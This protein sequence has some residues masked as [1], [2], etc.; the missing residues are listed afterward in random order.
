[1]PSN[2]T[3]YLMAANT[4]NEPIYDLGKEETVNF[5][6]G[7]L[8]Q[9]AAPAT[10]FGLGHL[11]SNTHS[12]LT[13]DPLPHIPFPPAVMVAELLGD[14]GQGSPRE[15]SKRQNRGVRDGCGRKGRI[16]IMDDEELIRNVAAEMIS[17]LGHEVESVA[18]GSAA[19]DAFARARKEG[20]PFDI[21]ILDL[22]V[23]GGMGGEE[24]ISKLRE[25][26][27]K[28]VAVVSS[29]YVDGP[30]LTNYREHGF[31][32]SLNKPYT[33]ESLG[34]CLNSLLK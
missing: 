14:P 2:E 3:K 5:F 25:M 33:I 28:I 20:R 22:T 7:E 4:P 29:G 12:A 27:S 16:L 15:E 6:S 9:K 8:M 10:S 30:A 21:V 23:R 13:G 34:N 18:D 31:S 11:V 26:D 19:I 17:A 24:T 1:M 32:A